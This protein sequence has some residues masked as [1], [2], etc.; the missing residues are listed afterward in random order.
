MKRLV[1]VI[2]CLLI[3]AA[4]AA[5]CKMAPAPEDM[6][7]DTQFSLTPHEYQLYVNKELTTIQNLLT[8][9]ASRGVDVQL[10]RVDRETEIKD[11]E[12]S[13]KVVGEI[14]AK[15][16][17]TKPPV[18]YEQDHSMLLTRI[19]NVLTAFEKYDTALSEFDGTPMAMLDE[20]FQ[21]SAIIQAVDALKAA[22]TEINLSFNIYWK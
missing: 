17:R 12:Q 2:L 3:A 22:H 15:L 18:D 16:K 4:A 13:T 6:E 1:A 11:V 14:Y 8:Q 10:G 20:S 21:K 7:Y 5:G 19:A 9:H